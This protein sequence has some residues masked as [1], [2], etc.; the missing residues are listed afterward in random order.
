MIEPIR[1]ED[2]PRHPDFVP[3]ASLPG[4]RVD[5]RY[6]SPD[7]FVGRD[8]YSPLDCGW[9]RREAG[10]A[11]ADAHAALQGEAPGWGFLVL[12]ALRPQRVQEALW[13]SL[14]GS[15]LEMYLAHP[16]RGSIHS[17]GMAV[18]ITLLDEA[19]VEQDMGTPFDDLTEKSHPR[20][21]QDFLDAG[22]LTLKQVGHRRLLRRVLGQAG[23]QGISTEWWH[24]DFGDREQVRANLPRVL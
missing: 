2:I 14:A 9:I 19:G 4:V 24:F 8:L 3:L 22:E 17:F 16:A 23:F 20:L 11:L 5:L 10:Q 12:D 13:A 18:D 1:C 7:N 21:E 15:G 6:G